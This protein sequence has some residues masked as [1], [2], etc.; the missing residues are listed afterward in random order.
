MV[1]TATPIPLIRAEA[2]AAEL[3]PLLIAALRV[4]ATVDQGIHGRRRVGSGDSFWQY[5][6]Y[7]PGE[8]LRRIDWRRSARSDALYVRENEWA[9]AQSIW[10]WRDASPSMIWRSSRQLATKAERAE[11]LLIALAALLNRG[12]ERFALLGGEGRAPTTGRFALRRLAD[13]LA[14]SRE[15][16]QSLPPFQPLPRYGHVVLFGDFLTPLEELRQRIA[17]FHS[18]GV[19][20]HLVQIL[21]PAERELPFSGRVRFAPLESESEEVMVPRVESIRVDYKGRME[22]HQQGLAD[23]ARAGDWGFI[24]LRTDASPV[25]SLMALYQALAQADRVNSRQGNG[26]R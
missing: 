18:R 8:S 6:R 24:R 9:A 12:G 1:T 17:Q 20:G 26:A 3:P 5:R 15:V 19:R 7:E 13:D 21:D 14:S 11:I 4:A 22:A 10:L 25:S 2:L 16:A 23:L